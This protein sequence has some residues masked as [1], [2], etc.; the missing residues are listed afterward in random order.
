MQYIFITNDIRLAVA[1]RSAGVTR[2]MVDL[3]QIGKEERQG[4]LDTLRSR[5]TVEDVAAVKA[6]VPDMEL[7]VR[8]NPLYRGS[9]QEVEQV[10]AA[11][12]DTIML[13]MF[14]SS[15]EA[16]RFLE[17]VSGRCKVILLVET[18]GSFL[19]LHRIVKIP[20]VS[21]VH[22]GLNDLHLDMNLKFMFEPLVLGMIDRAAE[23]VLGAGI[24]FGFGG[25]ARVG[26]GAIP[27]EMV[28]AEHERLGS[29]GVILSR[30]FHRDL[31]DTAGLVDC[32][33]L[34]LE[35]SKLNIAFK[36]LMA[37]TVQQREHGHQRF[38]EKIRSLVLEDL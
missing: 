2:V 37:R 18:Y 26:E 38:I 35:V 25:I 8:V 1:A 12:C 30:T 29:T 31:L 7:I 23:V 10:L 19:D 16:G 21:E 36:Q 3:E 4:H 24:R 13:P 27:G 17:L 28:L 20:G 33:T 6:V 9:P 15:Q 32:V 14:F 22:V 11:G 34:E 5:H